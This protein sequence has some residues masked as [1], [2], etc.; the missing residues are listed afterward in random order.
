[1]VDSIVSL[2]QGLAHGALGVVLHV[3]AGA[4]AASD[5]AATDA[6]RLVLVEGD[7]DAAQVLRERIVRFGLQA[8]V[9]E[10]VVAASEG[11]CDWHTFSLRRANGTT[12]AADLRPYYPRLVAT[13][14]RPVR[15]VAIQAVIAATMADVSDSGA[16]HALIVDLPGQ[17]NALL[18]AIEPT[19]VQRFR[20][21]I[22]RESPVRGRPAGN[23]QAWFA[24]LGYARAEATEPTPPDGPWPVTAY[25]L[26]EALALEMSQ[27]RHLRDEL[28]A[29]LA[30]ARAESRRLEAALAADRD[31]RAAELAALRQSLEAEAAAQARAQAEIA[32]LQ[33]RLAAQDN[34][35]AESRRLEAALAAD[36]DARAAELAA[37]RQSLEAEAAAQARAQAEI[38]SLQRRLA[39]QVVLDDTRRREQVQQ[40]EVRFRS[41]LEELAARHAKELEPLRAKACLHDEALAAERSARA[42]E[43]DAL[44]AELE[45]SRKL[46]AAATRERELLAQLQLVRE[47]DIQDLQ[48]RYAVLRGQ[49][50]EQQ[51]LL[52]RVAERLAAARQQF[53]RIEDGRLSSG[54]LRVLESGGETLRGPASP[55]TTQGPAARRSSG[56]RSRKA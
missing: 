11:S 54:S 8:D 24:R 47:G 15:C 4:D 1:M 32:S 21:V 29:A 16:P 55:A 5:H 34:E 50:Q 43:H 52:R 38:A 23:D 17:A 39:A 3:G 49:W 44:R 30:H 41:E 37:L 18:A 25:R 20:W 33:R 27:Q 36:R 31:A 40:V 12:A 35:R 42:N 56:P 10:A 6:E 26:D 19:L 9:R 46:L 45:Q 2:L 53:R 51:D 7:P 48:E 14:T 28:E 22:V 13:G